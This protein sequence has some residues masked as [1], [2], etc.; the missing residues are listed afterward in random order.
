MFATLFSGKVNRHKSLFCVDH[1]VIKVKV[2]LTFFESDILLH[3][4]NFSTLEIK[5]KG[6]VYIKGE[7]K[8]MYFVK[9]RQATQQINVGSETSRKV[10]VIY[11]YILPVENNPLNT[12][13]TISNWYRVYLYK[14]ITKKG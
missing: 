7:R 6:D 9:K 1:F 10:P 8:T 4:G 3:G 2:I 14:A 12:I 13:Y 5:N 11:S